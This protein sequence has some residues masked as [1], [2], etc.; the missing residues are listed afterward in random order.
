MQL[1]YYKTSFNCVGESSF[2]RVCFVA[3][4][5]R[6]RWSAAPGAVRLTKASCTDQ[7]R[8]YLP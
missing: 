4:K 8:C 5:Y 7:P 6:S 1:E 2:D 3:R